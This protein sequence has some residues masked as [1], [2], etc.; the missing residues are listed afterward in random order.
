MNIMSH[1]AAVQMLVSQIEEELAQ[2]EMVAVLDQVCTQEGRR[3][4]RRRQEEDEGDSGHSTDT[5][6]HSRTEEIM[7]KAGK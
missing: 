4:S 1:T 6:S 3:R 7:E 2:A 5:D